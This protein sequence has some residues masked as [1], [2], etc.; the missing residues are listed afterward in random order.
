MGSYWYKQKN[1]CLL[2]DSWVQQMRD[3]GQ[4]FLTEEF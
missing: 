4:I 1:K 2:I 3:K